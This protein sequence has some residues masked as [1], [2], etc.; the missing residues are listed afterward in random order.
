VVA[1]PAGGTHERLLA[2]TGALAAPDPPRVVG[3]VD[4][5]IAA[6]ELLEYLRRHGYGPTGEA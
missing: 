3:P 4:A 5:A 6:D 2:L 1:A